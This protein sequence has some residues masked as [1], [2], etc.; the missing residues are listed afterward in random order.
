MRTYK[1]LFNKVINPETL[2]FAWEEFKKGKSRKL[3]VLLF[4]QELERN[5]FQLARDLRTKNYKHGGYTGFYVSDP[6]L[7]HIHKATVRDRILH[8]AIIT[9]LN[10]VFERTFIANSFSCRVGKGSHKGVLCLR[11]MLYKESRNNTKVCYV[12]KCDVRK[13]FDSI[14][15]EVLVSILRKKIIDQEMMNLLENIVESYSGEK[16]DL[17]YKKGVPIGNLTSQLFANIYMNEF[18][19]FMKHTLKVKHYAR[20][21]DDFVIVSRNQKYLL[22]LIPMVNEF[23]G[24]ILKLELHPKKVEIISYSKGI[25]FLG[26]GLFP[27]HTLIRKKTKERMN[28]KTTLKLEQY[29]SRIIEKGTLKAS[30]QSYLGALSHANAYKLSENLK[31]YFLPLD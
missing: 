3:D 27:Y 22:Q 7:R 12:L 23:L 14:D 6:K 31:N 24:N 19:Q 21:T 2:F 17:F 16:S 15:H 4:E 8:H 1:D 28:K 11:K 5:I 13:F 29:K 25:D 9:V 18:D 10:P 26:Y 20:Y 30:W